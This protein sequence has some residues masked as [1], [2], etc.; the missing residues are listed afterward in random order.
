M[1]VEFK[2]V[3][4][5]MG[6]DRYI[7]ILTHKTD[8][9]EYQQLL[10]KSENLSFELSMID[11]EMFWQ[12]FLKYYNLVRYIEGNEGNWLKRYQLKPSVTLNL[13]SE[14]AIVWGATP[15]NIQLSE[16]TER[17]TLIGHP[18]N[19]RYKEHI[20]LEGE[21]KIN[22]GNAFGPIWQEYRIN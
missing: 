3:S 10:K 19:G 8:D 15:N 20:I 2:Y 13:P 9:F 7:P 16:E 18:A 12:C 22:V 5:I 21:F 4:S 14:L 6:L 1:V 17:T 11:D